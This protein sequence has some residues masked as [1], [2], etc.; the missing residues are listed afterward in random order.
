MKFTKYQGTGNDFILIEDHR[1]SFP[2]SKVK[3]V[4][5]RRYGVGADG[6]ILIKQQTTLD[7]LIEIFNADGSS[8]EMCG[9]GLRCV[10]QYLKDRGNKKQRLKIGVGDRRY[11]ACFDKEQIVI[12]MGIPKLIEKGELN[13]LPFYHL[14]S[15]VPHF[16]HFCQTLEQEDFTRIAANLR[17]HAHFSPYGVNVNFVKIVS[18]SLFRIRTYERGVE[19]ETFSCGTGATAAC[20]AAWKQFGMK[21]KID[22]EFRSK[23]RLQFDLLVVN[24]LLDQIYMRGT[25]VC[26][27]EGTWDHLSK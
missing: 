6:L 23:E 7:A 2:L 24:D 22:V 5:D 17:H 9:N 15:G 4:C 20:M 25:A 27:F 21:G 19:E 1:S 18:S 10:A 8:A 16:V 26:T 12:E 11:E 14:N 13:H 3:T